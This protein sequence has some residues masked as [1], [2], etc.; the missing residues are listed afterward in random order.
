MKIT[1]LVAAL[2]V[3][4]AMGA[5]AQFTTYTSESAFVAALSA[6]Y[7]LENFS[8]QTAFAGPLSS[9]SFSGGA[10]TVSYNV[11]ANPAGLFINNDSGLNAVGNYNTADD[12]VV[13]F[14]SPNVY[15]AGAEFYLNNLAGANQNG[16]ITINFS[17]GGTGSAPSS[18]TGPYGFF[19]II[20]T[21]PI[22]SMTVVHD[23]NYFLNVANLYSGATPVPEPATGLMLLMG[24]AGLA[25][26]RWRK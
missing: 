6:G 23:A 26:A 7:Y 14:T 5:S 18:A 11:T 17:G 1:K 25:C 2:L 12:V 24:V 8:S 15:A 19:G 22:T 10:P 13:T 9:L 3:G 16:S 4:G 20:S 21:T